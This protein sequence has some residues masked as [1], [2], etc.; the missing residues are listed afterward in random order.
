MRITIIHGFYAVIPEK[1]LI[2]VVQ[3]H[4]RHL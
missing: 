4:R 3:H 1:R 2:G